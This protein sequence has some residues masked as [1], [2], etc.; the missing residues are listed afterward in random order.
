M[1]AVEEVHVAVVVHHQH[2]L[3]HPHVPHLAHRLAV[4]AVED[5]EEV[6]VAEAE[7][8]VNFIKFF[9]IIYV[10]IFQNINVT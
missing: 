7:A 6:A 2:Q 9:Y 5:A 10:Q 8:E 1:A 3:V 4:D